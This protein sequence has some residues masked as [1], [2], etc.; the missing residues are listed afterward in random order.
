M[1]KYFIAILYLLFF[2]SAFSYA[3]P[4]SWKQEKKQ[5]T[6]KQGFQKLESVNVS[7]KCEGAHM[8]LQMKSEEI[9]TK[10][11]IYLNT[12]NK[13][14]YNCLLREFKGSAIMKELPDIFSKTAKSK[15]LEFLKGAK[16]FDTSCSLLKKAL[17]DSDEEIRKN[18]VISLKEQ[19]ECRSRYDLFSKAL[20][21]KS[22]EVRWW[23]IDALASDDSE[24]ALKL[25]QNALKKENNEELKSLIK[26]ALSMKAGNK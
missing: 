26:R 19:K 24:K 3:K 5:E 16:H 14:F 8:L 15:K 1:N 10:L 9:F 21:D 25:L 12:D 13:D 22:N 2:L 20:M 7:D 18:A 11:I 4:K 6:E 17:N 23:T